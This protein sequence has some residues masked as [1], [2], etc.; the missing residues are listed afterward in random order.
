M[1]FRKKTTTSKEIIDNQLKVLDISF[2]WISMIVVIVTIALGVFSAIRIENIQTQIDNSIT[3]QENKL[4]IAI[5]NLNDR[6]FKLEEKV[7]NKILNYTDRSKLDI[8]DALTNL[9]SEFDKLAG[10]TLKQ[11]NLELL[12]E[13]QELSGQTFEL[14]LDNNGKLILPS[15]VI[16]NKGNQESV[17][18]SINFGTSEEIEYISNNWIKSSFIDNNL[19]S[20]YQLEISSV[21]EDISVIKPGEKDRIEMITLALK[22]KNVKSLRCVFEIFYEREP[23]LRVAFFIRII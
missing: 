5:S 22:D 17:F 13:G 21:R 10:E 2:K 3:K 7:E 23:S 16:F 6:L 11:P 4:D 20:Q 18:P 1:L 15:I 9:N 19:K 12:Y 14:S 8:K